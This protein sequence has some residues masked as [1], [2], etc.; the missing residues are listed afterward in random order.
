MSC[1]QVPVKLQEAMPS[2]TSNVRSLTDREWLTASEAADYLRVSIQTLRNMTSNG[3]IPVFK[4][5]R[6]V[7]YSLEELRALLLQ[8]KRGA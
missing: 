4:L 7:R 6:R 8:S 3:Q 1:N 2:D 5:G